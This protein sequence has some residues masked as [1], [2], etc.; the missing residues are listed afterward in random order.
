MNYLRAQSAIQRSVT[1]EVEVIMSFGMQ[2]QAAMAV[3][4]HL[5]NLLAVSEA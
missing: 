5:L 3:G 4:I 2:P 1:V